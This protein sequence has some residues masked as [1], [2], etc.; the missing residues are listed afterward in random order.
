M[1]SR[2][3]YGRESSKANPSGL[4]QTGQRGDPAFE[5]YLSSLVPLPLKRADRQTLAQSAL[6]QLLERTGRAVLIGEGSGATM[7]WLAADAKPHLV[8]G[9]VAIEPAGPPAGT[10]CT[11]GADGV[12][13]YTSHIR[14]DPGVRPYG[15]TDIP[16][17]YEPPLEPRSPAK[18]PGST[19]SDEVGLDFVTRTLFDGEGTCMLQRCGCT[20]CGD[21]KKRSK[22][23]ERN[24]IRE[25]ANL[26]KM[27][28]AILTGEASSHS[29]YDWATAEYMRQAGVMVHKLPL[30]RYHIGGN[31]HLMFLERNSDFVAGLITI[32]IDSCVKKGPPPPYLS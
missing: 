3:V 31:G 17:T 21:G 5:S 24:I 26:R 18:S 14:L 2:D 27:P 13:R 1:F 19:T 30:E 9:V 23:G 16:L 29:K 20:A 15:L 8:V 28:H 11:V 10:A 25:L 22:V 4:S 6:S 7:A 12:R 32:W